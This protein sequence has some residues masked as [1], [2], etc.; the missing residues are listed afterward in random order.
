MWWQHL[1]HHGQGCGRTL[2]GASALLSGWACSRC[3]DQVFPGFSLFW[4]FWMGTAASE[5][6]PEWGGKLEGESNPPSW[7]ESWLKITG[8]ENRGNIWVQLLHHF[9]RAR[10]SCCLWA[11]AVVTPL[12]QPHRW[13]VPSAGTAAV[14]AQRPPATLCPAPGVL[15]E[16]GGSGCAAPAAVPPARPAGRL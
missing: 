16:P 2:A 14:P 6:V 13:H 11:T 7:V 5:T 12:L 15:G 10:S 8:N 9:R 4:L 3:G 1:C